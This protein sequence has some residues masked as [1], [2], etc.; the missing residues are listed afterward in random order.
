MVFQQ[1]HNKPESVLKRHTPSIKRQCHVDWLAVIVAL[2]ERNA[3]VEKL[4]FYGTRR[5]AGSVKICTEIKE[6]LVFGDTI[7]VLACE[8]QR[9]CRSSRSV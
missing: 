4:A 2:N 9:V 8:G 5:P 3:E 7:K 1:C 6:N